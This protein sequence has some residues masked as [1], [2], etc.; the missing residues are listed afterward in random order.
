MDY[1]NNA[2]ISLNILWDAAKA[3]LRGKLIMWASCIKSEKDNYLKDLTMRLKHL[4]TEHIK[5]TMMTP[6]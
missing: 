5:I 3:V 6:N 2:D 1:N 4:E